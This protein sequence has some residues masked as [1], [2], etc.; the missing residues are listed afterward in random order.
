M[1]TDAL[2]KIRWIWAVSAPILLILA[3]TTSKSDDAL[4]FWVLGL[5]AIFIA[6]N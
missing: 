2:K 4:L 5:L 3:L 1:A 6:G